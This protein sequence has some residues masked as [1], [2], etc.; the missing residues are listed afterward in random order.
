VQANLLSRTIGGNRNVRSEADALWDSARGEDC[1]SRD[2]NFD[3]RLG[4]KPARVFA[5]ARRGCLLYVLD[6]LSA[7][8]SSDRPDLGRCWL[9]GAHRWQRLGCVDDRWDWRCTRGSRLH[10]PSCR[11]Q[12]KHRHCSRDGHAARNRKHRVR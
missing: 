5:L 12:E 9:C 11:E 6:S 4:S 3:S 2:S 10:A 7:L 1:V 8:N